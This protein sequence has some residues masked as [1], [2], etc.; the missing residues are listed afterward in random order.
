M[1]QHLR[2][3]LKKPARRILQAIVQMPYLDG[4]PFVYA[5]HSSLG[6]RRVGDRPSAAFRHVEREGRQLSW[7]GVSSFKRLLLTQ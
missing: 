4:A 3:P 5:R 6:R 1:K 7:F 2:V